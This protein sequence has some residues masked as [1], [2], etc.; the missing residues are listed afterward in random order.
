MTDEPRLKRRG[1]ARAIFLRHLPA[2]TEWVASGRTLRA[3]YD[4]KSVVGIGYVQF[5]RY[6]KAARL[7]KPL[8]EYMRKKPQLTAEPKTTTANPILTVNPTTTTIN[9]S[10]DIAPRFK[11]DP[12]AKNMNDL[13]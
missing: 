13:I 6:A 7:T 3:Y 10:P 12:V 5:T 1:D 9:S 4:E 11:W 2:L 8:S